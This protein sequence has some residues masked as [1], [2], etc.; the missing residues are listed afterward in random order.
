MSG[1]K[2][3]DQ[4]HAF[5]MHYIA[6]TLQVFVGAVPLSN[7]VKITHIVSGIHE[8][9]IKAGV[10][11]DRIAAQFPDIVQFFNDAVQITDTVRI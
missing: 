5:F 10:H 2:V 8:R 7:F 9:G 3:Q 4:V 11:P 1:N 6:K